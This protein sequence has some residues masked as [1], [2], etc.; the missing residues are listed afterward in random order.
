[1]VIFKVLRPRKNYGGKKGHR[2]SQAA[3]RAGEYYTWGREYR[4]DYGNGLERGT[5]TVLPARRAGGRCRT[6]HEPRAWHIR[7]PS[8]SCSRAKAA[9]GSTARPSGKS[10]TRGKKSTPRLGRRSARTTSGSR[11]WNTRAGNFGDCG[12]TMRK[13]CSSRF[14]STEKSTESKKLCF[15]PLFF[16]KI[17]PCEGRT[18]R[19]G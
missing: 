13:G 9:C 10:R 1:M 11:H 17:R 6:G 19:G 5:G 7:T 14:C 8:S 3:T 12:N 18:C 15:P 2:S 4:H 16:A